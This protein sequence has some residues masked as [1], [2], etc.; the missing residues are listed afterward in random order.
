MDWKS[1]LPEG[2]NDL[3]ETAEGFKAAITIPADEDGYI[4]RCCPGCKGKFRML[5]DEYVALPDET[6]LTCPYCG[7][8]EDAGEFMTEAQLNRTHAAG[9][10]VA[11]QWVHDEKGK[12]FG[13]AFGGRRSG[14]GGGMFRVEIE[15]RPS[16]PPRVRSLPEIVDAKFLSVVTVSGLAV[17]QRLV[18]TRDE[19][20]RALDDVEQ[21]VRMLAAQP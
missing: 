13:N 14:Y 1:R 20:L 4:G 2:V 6:R 10:A 19:A 5:S 18:I 15:H 21:V 3:Q 7:L 12:I 16:P 9:A 17:G 11:E 8:E